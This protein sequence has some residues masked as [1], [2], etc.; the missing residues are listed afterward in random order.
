MTP[1]WEFEL[2]GELMVA[3]PDRALYWPARRILFVADVHLGKAASFRAAGVPLPEGTTRGNLLRLTKLL[4]ETQAERLI[5]LGDLWHAKS[6]RVEK[7]VAE[8]AAWRERHSGVEMILVEGNHDVRSGALPPELRMTEVG[9]C[10]IEG[11]FAL[12][13]APEPCDQGYVLAGHV[14]PAVRMVGQGQQEHRLPCFW[15]GPE[16]GVLPAFG[17]FTGCATVRPRASD[18]V[19]VIACDRVMRV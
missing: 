16:V 4:A 7:T 2:K 5:V 8:V 15:F 18:Q 17:E 1:T 3:Y 11:P 6:G 9:D 13:H 14:H 19:F 10:L 12:V